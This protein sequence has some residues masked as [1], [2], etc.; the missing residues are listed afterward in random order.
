MPIVAKRQEN[1]TTGSMLRRFTRMVQ[2]SGVLIK[3]RRTQFF[4]GPKSERE[5]KLSALYR[6]RV[7][8][9]RLRLQKLGIVDE[10]EIKATIQKLKQRWRT[11]S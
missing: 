7:R 10:E 1:E 6:D 2:Q 11:I 3:A 5:R 9:E 4:Q 8:K